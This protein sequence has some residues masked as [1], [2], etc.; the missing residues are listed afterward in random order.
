MARLVMSVMAPPVTMA[1]TSPPA[2]ILPKADRYRVDIRNR[3]WKG[4]DHAR[5]TVVVYCGFAGY[6]CRSSRDNFRRIVTGRK[7]RGWP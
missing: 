1:V 6:Y 4:A 2:S 7:S 5:A 3:P